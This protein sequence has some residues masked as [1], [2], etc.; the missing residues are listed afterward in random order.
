M[1]RFCRRLAKG[2]FD[3]D[4]LRARTAELAD[5]VAEAATAYGFDAA[6]VTAAGYS[7]G[8]NIA[9]SLLLL[10]PLTLAGAALFRPMVPLQPEAAPHLGGTPVLL[11]AGRQDALVAP[12]ETE[13]LSALLGSYGA[14]VTVHWHA[15]G[16][17]LGPDDVS[18]VQQW[19]AAHPSL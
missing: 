19:L 11:A 18:A 10:R 17:G 2:V 5:F 7:N 1:P 14:D 6:R 4:G 13:R 16:H 15:G 8:A 12:Q 9:A 3:L